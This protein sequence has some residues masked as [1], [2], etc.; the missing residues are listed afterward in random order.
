MATYNTTFFQDF[1][2]P[3]SRRDQSYQGGYNQGGYN[4]GA[5][6][7][8]GYNQGSYNQ[9]GYN[10]GG[11]QGQPLPTGNGWHQKMGF[12][13]PSNLDQ[14]ISTIR[15]TEFAP[16]TREAEQPSI[17]SLYLQ[18]QF[19][20]LGSLQQDQD[21]GMEDAPPKEERSLT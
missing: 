13:K 1:S 12:Q 11:F 21:Y 10:Q 4:Q 18:Q 19:G 7:Q 8:G 14:S 15:A 9:G 2:Q 3:T 6:N 5:Y 20:G 17:A 16:F